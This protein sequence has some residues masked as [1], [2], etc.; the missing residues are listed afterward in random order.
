MSKIAALSLFRDS[1]QQYINEYFDR[2]E[3][4]MSGK[5]NIDFYLV[6]GD[7]K[8]NTFDMLREKIGRR[9]KIKVFK[10]DTGLPQMG[11]T[12]HETRFKCLTRTANPIIDII[13]DKSYDYFWFI[14]S[15]LIYNSGL[16]ERLISLDLDV[17]APLSMAAT[18]LYDIWAFRGLNGISVG[19][20]LNWVNGLNP[21][22]LS[23]VGGCV[24][25]RHEFIRLGARMT[26]TESIVGLCKESAKLGASV[27]A[28]P[29]SVVWHPAHGV[30][31]EFNEHMKKWGHA[32]PNK[33]E[34]DDWLSFGEK[35]EHFGALRIDSRPVA[36]QVHDIRDLSAFQKSSFAG[37]ECHH[38]LE[39]LLPWDAPIA[40]GE[41]HKVMRPGAT[42]EISVPDLALC[43]RL[44]LE[45]NTQIFENIFSPHEEEEQR[46]RWG[47]TMSTLTNVLSNAGFVEIKRV[48]S[49]IDPNEIR[50]VCLKATG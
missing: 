15:D 42:L 10:S 48:P 36:D 31:N 38:V 37:V 8:N 50:I 1:S 22:E 47:Y 35:T 6:E 25:V 16:L 32:L 26:E 23:S 33:T 17:V 39:H 34:F 49:P 21:I 40:L 7:S 19:P 43:S 13:A 41:L 27:W 11:S 9:R 30:S 28:D 4:I 45:G 24:L 29:G 20:H 14:D 46:H 5:N 12:V 2:A 3:A 18:V 44:V